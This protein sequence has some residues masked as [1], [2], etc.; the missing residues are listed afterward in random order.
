[1]PALV[2]GGLPVQTVLDGAWTAEVSARIAADWPGKD[3]AMGVWGGLE[4]GL[5]GSGRDGVLVGGAGWLFTAEEF[6]LPPPGTDRQADA[7]ALV[8]AAVERLVSTEGTVLVAIVPDKSRVCARHLGRHVRPSDLEHRYDRLRDALAAAGAVVPDLRPALA[9]D[10]E[11]APFLRTDT[12]WS[13]AGAMVAAEAVARALPAP[14]SPTA[15]RVDEHDSGDHRGDLVPFLALGA[16]EPWLAPAPDHLVRRTATPLVAALDAAALFGE[17]S[18][19]VVL[20]G[21]SYSAD[22]RFGFADG[23]RVQLQRE[24]DNR[25]T[26]GEGPFASMQR[27]LADAQAAPSILIWELPERYLAVSPSEVRHASS[28]SI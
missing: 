15:F 8:E 12:H 23:L 22:T 16:L 26:S 25:A 7:V 18:L 2:R 9:C 10:G 24:V 19:P 17:V 14:D 11:E 3:L 1:M 6:E 5:L 20:V 27:W 13:P 4:Y 21:T 28:P